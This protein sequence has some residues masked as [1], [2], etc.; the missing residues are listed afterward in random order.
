METIHLPVFQRP[1]PG[2]PRPP[3]T[4]PPATPEA[5]DT[6]P[7]LPADVAAPGAPAGAALA[8]GGTG[9]FTVPDADADLGFGALVA[10]ESRQRLL[11]PDGSFNVARDGLGRLERLAPYHSLLVMG[12]GEFLLYCVGFYL[13]I[14]LLFAALYALGG[15]GALLDA[16]ETVRSGVFARAFFF[17]VETFATIGYGSIVPVGLWANAVMTVESL[18]GT[19]SVALVTGLVFARFSRPT[20]RVR[21]SRRAVVGPYRDGTALMFRLVNERRSEMLQLELR[22]L[23]SYVDAGSGSRARRFR[24]LALERH[25]VTFLPLAWTVVHPITEASPLHALTPADLEARDA[26]ILVLL[27]GLDETTTQTLHARTSYKP[28]ELLHG[29][30]FRSVFAPPRADGTL[31]IDVTRL[32]DVDVA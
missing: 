27:S 1:A 12:W 17:S 8:T 31:R 18:A 5:S 22:V 10:R 21:F 6:A 4:E 29:A 15:P 28:H 7:A 13:A 24:E 2:A 20:A 19:L 25:Q 26:E 14:N 23:F 16:A 3:A 9:A 11:N 30:R 32:D